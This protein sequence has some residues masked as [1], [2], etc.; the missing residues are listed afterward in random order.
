MRRLF[1]I[2]GLSALKSRAAATSTPTKVVLGTGAVLGGLELGGR[3]IQKNIAKDAYVNMVKN[4]NDLKTHEELR[5]K[6]MSW[7]RMRPSNLFQKKDNHDFDTN[8]FKYSRKFVGDN[9]DVFGY[10]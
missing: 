9:K 10:N 7:G 6:H 2:I 1:E 5:D 4:P 8:I 3:S